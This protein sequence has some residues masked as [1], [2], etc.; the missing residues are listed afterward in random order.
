MRTLGEASI[1]PSDTS[2]VLD[3][4]GE[5]IC[6][7]AVRKSSNSRSAGNLVQRE[8]EENAKFIKKLWNMAVSVGVTDEEL[9]S[10]L[11]EVA[12]LLYRHKKEQSE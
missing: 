2:L 12:V 6:S 1:A 5:P 4:L 11:V 8:R 10:G 3:E 7:T 9:D